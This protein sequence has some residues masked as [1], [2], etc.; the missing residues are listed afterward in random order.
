[1]SQLSAWVAAHGVCQHAAWPCQTMQ[2]APVQKLGSYHGQ[3]LSRGSHLFSKWLREKGSQAD[4]SLPVTAPACQVGVTVLLAVRLT[5]VL[6]LGLPPALVAGISL[7]QSAA[8][9]TQ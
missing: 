1:M 8:Q 9:G 4:P 5:A 7:G 3:S 2:R 6:S